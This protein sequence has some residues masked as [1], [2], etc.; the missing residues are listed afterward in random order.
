MFQ[1]YDR[2]NGQPVLPIIYPS[3]NDIIE[4]LEPKYLDIL[5]QSA[6]GRSMVDSGYKVRRTDIM[7]HFEIKY[8]VGY[9]IQIADCSLYPDE[10]VNAVFKT[11][12]GINVAGIYDPESGAFLDTKGNEY[13]V[14]NLLSFYVLPPDP[15]NE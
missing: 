10:E 13:E 12:K 1:A 9:W 5:K 11:L 2:T 15:V 8:A 7:R 3:E 4:Q 14:Y 6:R